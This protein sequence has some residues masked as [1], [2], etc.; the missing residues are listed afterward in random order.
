MALLKREDKY[1]VYGASKIAHADLWKRLRLEWPE[2]HFTARWPTLHV[3]TVP[4]EPAFAS[5][6]W[7]HDL[8]DIRSADAVLVY[9]E[10]EDKLRGAL[11]EAGMALALRQRVVVVGE[12]PDF[13]TWQ[14]HPL[15]SRVPDLDSARILFKALMMKL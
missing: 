9:A 13:G 8:A 15:V 7:E 12:H 14:Y 5:V 2:I 4:D 1:S 10:P 6:F 3:G 11:V